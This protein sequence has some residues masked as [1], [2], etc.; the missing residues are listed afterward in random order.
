MKNNTITFRYNYPSDADGQK[1][2]RIDNL[3]THLM[4]QAFWTLYHRGVITD[5]H[6][7]DEDMN[8]STGE[9]DDE[10]SL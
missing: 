3:I 6:L 1:Q 5:F 2:C 4:T 8:P 10:N 7:V 9:Q